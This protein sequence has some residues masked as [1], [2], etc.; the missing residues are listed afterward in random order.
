MRL[1]RPAVARRGDRFILRSYSPQR[2]IGGGRVLDPDA[3]KLKAHAAA[4]V[5]ER[6]EALDRGTA[7]DVV[8]ACAASGG[9]AGLRIAALARYGLARDEIP[10]VI[11]ALVKAGRLVSIEGRI[12]DARIVAETARSL[13]AMIEAMSAENKLLWGV[14]RGELKERASLR[15]GPLFEHLMEEGKQ[16][17]TLFFKGARVRAGSGE[18]EL[19]EADE[20][21]LRAI[22]AR[23]REAG[24]A[25]ATKAD[26]G[27]IVRDEKRLVSYLHIL[28]DRG[29][30]VRIGSDGAM[31]ADAYGELLDK[32]RA[33][34]RD[35]GTLAVGD[36][37]EMFGFSRKFAVPILE[38]LDR[39]GFTRREGDARRAGPKFE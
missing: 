2:V 20:K 27:A 25:F 11:D 35:G 13:V 8:V 17:G 16:R 37:K 4:S 26:L 1:E 12:F 7:E 31:H 19:S 39:E 32:V 14:D 28:A 6:L 34:L 18:R 22:E 36:F 30:I 24:H 9:A 21:A 10:G 3:P 23:I 15:E 38:H 29:A 33:R 5:R